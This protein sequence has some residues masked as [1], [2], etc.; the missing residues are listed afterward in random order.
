L[1]HFSQLTS[2]NAMRKPALKIHLAPAT[3]IGSILLTGC[4]A[5]LPY[6]QANSEKQLRNPNEIV[7][8]AGAQEASAIE[9]VGFVESAVPPTPTAAGDAL[10]LTEDIQSL[11]DREVPADVDPVLTPV[12]VSDVASPDERIAML[13]DTA[14]SSPALSLAEVEQLALANQPSLSAASAAVSKSS[15]LYRQVGRAPNPMFG[16]FGQQL[17][18]RNTDQHGLFVEQ[19]IVRGGK[20]ELN[21]RVL[22]HTTQAQRFELQTQ[23]LRVLT[24]A[25]TR[26]FDVVAAQMEL[27][28]TRQFLEVARKGV[29][30]A[31]DRQQAEE[32]SLVETLQ[33]RTLLSETELGLEQAEAA[34]QGAWR[35]L[36]ALLGMSTE[37]SG[38]VEAGLPAAGDRLDW[39]EQFAEI[40]AVS[41]E[42]AVARQIVCEK[43]A[44]LDRQRVQNVPNL[45]AQ[46]GAGQ[47]EG[48][49]HGMINVQVA[50]P[51]P[52][53]NKN[54]GNISAAYADY[55]RA[56]HDVKRLERSLR[57]R[58][59]RTGRDYDRARA[60][61]LRYRDEIIPQVTKSLELAEEAYTAG[62]LDFLQV[63]VLRQNYFQAAVRELRARK[64]LAQTTAIVDGL[65]LTGGDQASAD[66][67]AGDG[68]RGASFG[69]Q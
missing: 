22:A 7:A 12:V 34:Y 33:A 37:P 47:D 35:D 42:L 2:V 25:R 18:D 15:G 38:R 64:D 57:A 23:R 20:L 30:V 48:T 59:A 56:T 5:A 67:T 9:H 50:A 19:E 58:L 31:E 54:A 10:R 39:E 32:G 13:P 1:T 27:D 52:V 68:L 63:L 40:S 36:S 29:R 62:E 11:G 16:Y 46:L 8:D 21:Q 66:Y 44:I 43:K 60:A 53:W 28:L 24:D 4:T 26:F 69:G 45:V 6:S 51:I 3:A 65:L 41:P 17:A 55:V 61:V 49:N 14:N